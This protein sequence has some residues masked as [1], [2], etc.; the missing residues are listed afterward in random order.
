MVR[1]QER[2]CAI[3]RTKK[4]KE[5][6]FRFLV[7][8]A[9]VKFDKGQKGLSRGFYICSK[10]CWEEGVKK[11][12]RIKISSRENKFIDLPEIDFEAILK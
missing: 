5:K 7:N 1:T 8:G 3:C 12:K 4:P 9:S 2:T 10:E 11:K 6:L